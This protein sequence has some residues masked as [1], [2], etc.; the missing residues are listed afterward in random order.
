[1][2]ATLVAGGIGMSR[3]LDRPHRLP[4]AIGAV[5]YWDLP[6]SLQAVTDH[7]QVIDE[8]T[9]WW[10]GLGTDGSVISELPGGAGAEQGGLNRVATTGLRLVPSVAD[11][12]DGAWAPAVVQAILHDPTR[13]Q[14]HE[15]ALVT[16][17]T[18]RGFT[19]LQIDY[20]DLTAADRDVFTQ[21]IGELGSALHTRGKVLYVT[22]HPKTT[23]AGYDQ[24]NLAQD[25][26][27]L[28]RSAD[29][30]AVMAYDWH[31]TSSS[32]GPIAPAWWVADVLRYATS[33]IPA[34][35][36]V[37][38]VGLYGYDWVAQQGQP[39]LWQ[40]VDTLARSPGA[41]TGWDP[42]SSSP[43]LR[44]DRDGVHHEVWYEDAHSI[45]AKLD[46]A[47]GFHLG[48]VELWRLGAEDPGL[49]A[50]LADRHHNR[51]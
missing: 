48:G 32:A 37:L 10:Y 33:R 5:P 31:W 36:L 30:V 15:Q 43:Y 42:T 34:D 50:G 26:A 44:Y 8:A 16:L 27:A 23:D 2:V 38:G 17:A 24:R 13:R 46:L 21:F 29:K 47:T 3:L 19:G 25:Y 14:A 18:T 51:S 1:M 6:N 4:L 45:T 7:A 35:K 49:W 11:T 22:V 39:I 20:E 40:Q 28:G 12:T 41:T 9:P